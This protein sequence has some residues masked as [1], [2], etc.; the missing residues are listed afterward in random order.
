MS[1][2]PKILA[3]VTVALAVIVSGWLAS[4]A[5][6]RQLSWSE[7]AKWPD[8]EGGNWEFIGGAMG[9]L[10]NPL[11]MP[12]KPAIMAVMRTKFDAHGKPKWNVGLPGYS[13]TGTCEPEGLPSFTGTQFFYTRAGIFMVGDTDY[14]TIDRRIYMDGRGHDHPDPTFYGNSIG[15]WEGDTLVIDTVGFF[16]QVQVGWGVPGQGKQEIIERYRLTGPGKAELKLTIID[17]AVLTKPYTETYQMVLTDDDE[18]PELFCTNNRDA[19]TTVDLT[20]P[21]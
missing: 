6:A 17:P 16:A 3:R 15:H 21:Q 1:L 10:P 11:K 20:P 5:Q 7:I 2:M 8:L 13:Q 9:L 12:L 18:T 14:S 19:T 4:S